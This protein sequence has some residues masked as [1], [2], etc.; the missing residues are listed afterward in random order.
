MSHMAFH[1]NTVRI[2][3][4]QLLYQRWC[5]YWHSDFNSAPTRQLVSLKLTPNR[6]YTSPRRTSPHQHLVQITGPLSHDRKWLVI[7]R[8]EG[9]VRP[10]KNDWFYSRTAIWADQCSWATWHFTGI[11]KGFFCYNCCI[12]AGATTDTLTLTPH[13]LASWYLY[14]PTTSL[15]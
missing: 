13:R 2:F 6:S 1:W 15:T 3:L 4:L 14:R 11:Q 5:N 7:R 12:S 8:R 10:V 9:W